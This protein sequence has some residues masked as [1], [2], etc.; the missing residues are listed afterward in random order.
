MAAGSQLFVQG[1]AHRRWRW[2]AVGCL[3]LLFST[4]FPVQ[5]LAALSV[6]GGGPAT[7]ASQLATSASK[8]DPAVLEAFAGK[9]QVTYLVWL[10]ERADV[11]RAAAEARRAA[12]PAQKELNARTAVIQA[13]Q[14]TADRSQADLVALLEKEQEKGNVSRLER[15][16]VTNMLVVTSTKE[17]LEL[18][19]ARPEVER[20]LPDEEIYLIKV[21][22]DDSAGAVAAPVD[23]AAPAAD[24]EAAPDVGAEAV[25]WNIQRVGAP[26]VWQQFGVDGTGAVVASLD[27]GVQ[28][29]HPALLQQYRGNNPNGT[30]THT[31]SWYDAVN[32]RTTPYDDH[33]HGTHTV[34]TAVG[35]D[36]NGVNQIGVAPGAKWIAAKI[37]NASGSGSSSNI[38]RAGQWVLAPGGDPAKA[39]DVVNNSWGGS[40]GINDWFRSV[41]VA[42]RA[43]G[44]V[45]IFANGNSGPGSG[46]A[47]VP[48]NYPESIAVGA[49]D[50]SDNLA[51]F[52]SRGPSA[53]GVVK[54]DLSA[55]G[56]SIR[57]AVPG[58]GY[59]GGWSGTS[60]AAPHVA[61]VVALLRSADAGLTVDEIEEILI[62]S[63]DPRTDSTYREVPNN[64]YGYGIVNAYNAV[65][66]VLS[67]AG[68]LSDRN[69]AGDALEP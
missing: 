20:I 10:K 60:M 18:V 49:T 24:S 50:A 33:G 32:G 36:S 52:S 46:T 40:A 21:E 53:Y 12:E 45:P 1:T 61:G 6:E 23:D 43:A 34:G 8:I 2:G 68:N 44:I 13:L 14:E 64:G 58:G 29:T 37:L 22:D 17:V 63:A 67:G 54:P 66:Q 31:Y 15:Y 56:V 47:G 38:L 5:S 16:W 27:T 57:S 51:S 3:A 7:E 48:G 25:E 35:R 4:A 59:Q 28:W 39:P 19:A 62:T 11:V 42:W 30:V 41:V 9:E 65:A 55:P 26:L 69:A